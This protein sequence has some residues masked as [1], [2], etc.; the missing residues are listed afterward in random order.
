MDFYEIGSHRVALDARGDVLAATPY[1][2]FLADNIPEMRGKIAVDLGT[3]SGILGIVAKLQGA[4]LVYILDINPEAID[5]ALENAA[6]NGVHDGFEPLPTGS[7][8]LPLPDGIT[9]D[10]IICNPAQLPMRQSDTANDPFFA[11]EDGRAMIEALVHEA[12][13]WLA[14]DGRLLMTH[15]SL[16]DVPSTRKLMGTLGLESRVLAERSIEFRPFIDREWIDQLGGAE[17]GLYRIIDGQA[18]EILYIL[19]AGRRL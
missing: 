5:I 9:V 19:E 2:L 4:A 17:R 18:H 13:R 3:G 8:M 16:S 7:A 15:N 11:G 1:S 12:P 14:Q 6:R 10:Y